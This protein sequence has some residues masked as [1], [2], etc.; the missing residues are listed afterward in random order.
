MKN[1]VD[2]MEVTSMVACRM[3]KNARTPYEHQEK[4]GSKWR[5]SMV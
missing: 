4:E 2:D 1:L 3:A 5:R